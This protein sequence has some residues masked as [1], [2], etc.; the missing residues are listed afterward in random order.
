M[1]LVFYV[2]VY[3]CGDGCDGDWWGVG[4]GVDVFFVVGLLFVGY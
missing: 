4:C 3:G 1:C 2:V